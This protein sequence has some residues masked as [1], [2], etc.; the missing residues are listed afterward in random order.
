MK[1]KKIIP[2][3]LLSTTLLL[4]ACGTKQDS[5]TASSA[6]TAKT[7][8]TAALTPLALEKENEL[9]G[10]YKE[11]DY[12]DDETKV[13]TTITLN[14]TTG[15]VAG[16]GATIS[17][18]TLKITKGG[19]YL[20]TGTFSGSVEINTTEEV[21]LILNN[22]T[23]TN[24]TGAA[25]N[26]LE[27]KK[28]IVTLASGSTNEI[29]DGKSYEATGEDDPNS[30]IYSK[31]DLTF[32]GSG[33]LKVTGNYS[34]AIQSKDD[35]TFISGTYAVS[36]VNNALKGK[37]KVAI[38]AG[39]FTLTTTQGD[40]IQA[41]NT[42]ETD[43][44]YI[45]IDGGEFSIT[46]GSDGLQGASALYVQKATMNITTSGSDEEASYK[47]LKAGNNLVVDS[48]TFTLTTQDDGLHSDGDVTINGGELTVKT[49]DDG[50][51][52]EN[53]LTIN[54][55]KIAI[56][57]SYE[58][59]EGANIVLNGGDV[60]VNASDDGVNAASAGTST[61][62]DQGQASNQGDMTPPDGTGTG[63]TPPEM[64]SD[65]NGEMPDNPTNGTDDNADANS[66]ASTQNQRPSG[67]PPTGGNGGF[68]GGGMMENDGSTLVIN[69]GTL[70]VNA[71]G[72]GLDSN[73]DITMT[74]GTVQV[75]GPTNG[76]NGTLDYGGTFNLTGGTL[77]GVGSS[78]MAQTVSEDSSQ[79]NLA[80][81][82]DTATTA[83]KVTLTQNGKTL[84]TFSPEKTFQQVVFSSA[85]LTTGEVTITIDD[86]TYT[87]TLSD[88]YNSLAQDGS[89]Y[90]GEMGMGGGNGG[91]RK[92]RPDNTTENSTNN[93]NNNTTLKTS[94]EGSL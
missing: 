62:S 61:T 57:E 72:D 79:V 5:Q 88:T 60:S 18:N 23:L 27:S 45:A 86:K 93:A 73:G 59:L 67:T 70:T 84:I 58:G 83:K 75:F 25:L 41:S 56:L 77:L 44:G 90:S 16:S 66:G 30:A 24:E 12:N 4:G 22:V 28:V 38:L 55:G 39:N 46:S 15:E 19:N 42:D 26:I 65:A 51:H 78:G 76:G 36:A 49:G 2:Y 68:G 54:D 81:Y 63:Q 89:S 94:G 7:S 29:S 1:T 40:A 50:I 32:N 74:G 6:T 9:Y 85:E 87:V 48:G 33:S 69:G 8:T 80:F 91:D 53:N 3:L 31:A 34:N 14:K 21:H 92:Q 37:D 13:D 43:K 71:D 35:L 20:I 47:G 52:G 64:P 17:G 11:E 82:L 10:N